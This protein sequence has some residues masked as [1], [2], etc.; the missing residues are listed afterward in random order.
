M[1]LY[2]TIEL[3]GLIIQTGFFAY[4]FT[5]EYNYLQYEVCYAF[6]SFNQCVLPLICMVSQWLKVAQAFQRFII[7]YKQECLCLFKG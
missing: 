1:T 2:S 7:F 6:E 4:I 5:R 3:L